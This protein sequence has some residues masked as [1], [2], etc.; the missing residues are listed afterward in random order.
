M[1]NPTRAAWCA[2]FAQALRQLRPHLSEKFA[3][4]IADVHY[5]TM[6]TLDPRTEAQGYHSRQVD[7][8]AARSSRPQ[9]RS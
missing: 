4:T 5:S 2:E 7:H 8:V 1:S 3:E 9:M 6:T